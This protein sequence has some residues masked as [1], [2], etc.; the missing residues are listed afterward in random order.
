[1]LLRSMA[2]AV[3]VVGMTGC[4][5]LQSSGTPGGPAPALLNAFAHRAS[6]SHLVLYWNCGRSAPD[7]LRLEGI[8]QNPWFVEEIRA[9]EFEL[10]GVGARDRTVSEVKG[11]ARDTAIR[12]NQTSP[13]LL[14]LRTVG[15]ELRFDLY[16]QYQFAEG[17]EMDALLA[18]PPMVPSRFFSPGGNRFLVRDVCSESQHR[19]R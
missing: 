19:A 12:T 3:L 7:V 13:F 6:S 10:V 14:E 17:E 9:L 2:V 15:G 1:M 5:S 18:G 16:Y 4:A 8:A 11:E